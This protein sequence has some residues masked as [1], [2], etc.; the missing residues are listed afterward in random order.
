MSAQMGTALVRAFIGGLL[1]GLLTVLTVL[2]QA[3][4][5]DPARV[6]KALIAGGIALL[7]YVISRGGIEGAIDS[8]RAAEGDVKPS[9]VGWK[10]LSPAQRN[11]PVH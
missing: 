3:D 8:S 6:E 4:A 7:A 10:L 9:D 5:G 1:T 11:G 2:Q